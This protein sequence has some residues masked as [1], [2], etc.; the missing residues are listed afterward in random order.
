[1]EQSIDIANGSR[2]GLP[3]RLVEHEVKGQY[4]NTFVDIFK[5]L[6]EIVVL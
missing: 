1:V 2:N 5:K 6:M 4:P 3:A